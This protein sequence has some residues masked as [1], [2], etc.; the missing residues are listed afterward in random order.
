[1]NCS[2]TLLSLRSYL[3]SAPLALLALAGAAHAQATD[4][5]WPGGGFATLQAAINGATDVNNDNVVVVQVAAGVR[6]TRVTIAR[7]N[8]VLRG[9]GTLGTTIQFTG[10]GITPVIRTNNASNVVIENLVV[11]GNNSATGNTGIQ[12]DG[13]SGNI[14]RNSEVRNA[15]FGVVFNL[16]TN[17]LIENTRVHDNRL[18]GIEVLG[19]TGVTVRNLRADHNL[20]NGV[21]AEGSTNTLVQNVLADVNAVS[22]VRTVGTIGTRVLG[23]TMTAGGGEG[24]RV[25]ADTGMVVD[26][27]T[28]TNNLGF[29]IRTR[30]TNADYNASL[31]G[32]Q[33]PV[34]NNVVTGNVA[35]VLR[36]G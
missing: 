10:G 33:P 17:G 27:N 24:L 6:S 19:S 16:T 13:G 22:G 23:C 36:N 7:S 3:L 20:E 35:G 25:R 12:I 30:D 11:R 14:V 8:F 31:G 15:A 32:V 29:G 28:I 21:I 18:D 1:M 9:T 4:V 5:T 2:S 26:G 34:G